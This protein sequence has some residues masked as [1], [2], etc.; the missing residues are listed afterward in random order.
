MLR[1]IFPRPVVA[2]TAMLVCAFAGLR[3]GAVGT[4]GTSPS[5]SAPPR[6]GAFT[7]QTGF[8]PNVGQFGA[9]ADTPGAERVL[10]A[11]HAGAL[12]VYCTPTGLSY[13][14]TR[15]IPRSERVLEAT[16]EPDGDLRHSDVREGFRVDVAF[17]QADPR[18][19]VE[20]YGRRVSSFNFLVG[21]EER[22]AVPEFDHVVYRGVY[23]DIDAVVTV[24]GTELRYAFIVHPGGDPSRIA[25]QTR[26][27]DAVTLDVR[28][29]CVSSTKIGGIRET[30]PIAFQPAESGMTLVAAAFELDGT[31]RRMHVADYDRSR[32]LVIDPWVTYFGGNVDDKSNAIATDQ[33][34]NIIFTGEMQSYDF[35][36]TPG[37]F[38]DTLRGGIEAFFAK[39]D[40]TGVRLYAT[41]IGGTGNDYGNAVA[42]GANGEVVI[43]G[44]TASTNFPISTGAFQTTKKA[45]EDMFLAK[46]DSLGARVWITYYGGRGDDRGLSVVVDTMRNIVIGGHTLSDDLATT[47]NAFQKKWGGWDDGFVTKFTAAGRRIWTTYYGGTRGERFTGVAVGEKDNIYLT[48]RTWSADFP[49]SANALQDSLAGTTNDEDAFVVKMDSSGRR[50]WATYLGGG[51]IEVA[52]AIAVD[53]N[54]NLTIAGRTTSTN[55]P[56]TPGALQS[57]LA[58]GTDAFM[59]SLDSAGAMR[60]CTYYGGAAT[61]EAFGVTADTTGAVIAV[62]LTH[63]AN[64]P[65]AGGPYTTQVGG[66]DMFIVKFDSTGTRS[67]STYFG[68]SGEDYATSVTSYRTIIYVSGRTASDNVP[69][70]NPLHQKKFG[71]DA[72]VAAFTNAGIVPVELAAF[73]AVWDG[74]S[75]RLA[76]STESETSNAGFEIE[77]KPADGAGDWAFRGFVAGRG[78]TSQ[79]SSYAFLDEVESGM[80]AVLYRLRQIDHDGATSYSPV[81]LL[82]RV[83][84][85]QRLEITDVHPHPVSAQARLSFVTGSE[86]AAEVTL[87]DAMGRAVRVLH[88]SAAQSV[89]FHRVE[90]GTGDLPTGIYHVVVRQGAQQAT[91]RLVIAR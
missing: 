88:A 36:T 64:L 15:M 27:A 1:T 82:S 81:V 42:I 77:R 58:V 23:P 79:H 13:V 17:A 54:R 62:G 78:T 9:A 4:T 16:L 26:G 65:M 33:R 19:V 52:N 50:I 24:K 80:H 87:F 86:G 40:A 31:V 68:G 5:E 71:T 67:W 53:R 70:Y 48:G 60:W 51:K 38:Q 47:T 63:S 18:A 12:R 74:G 35:P 49:I 61:D 46:F 29:D 43:T 14:R 56:V 75:A 69:V 66:Q 89:G 3:A 11:A 6:A 59:A 57:T 41:C 39:F 32:T 2:V 73:T 91:R 25:L 55:L 7:M 22:T 90:F 72:L 76:W 21:S 10:Y 45:G 8:M 30:A 28:G 44:T 83:S 85:V 34:G 84:L 20:A 37:S